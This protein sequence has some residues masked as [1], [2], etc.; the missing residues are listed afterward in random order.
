[1]LHKYSS[2]SKSFIKFC[3][4]GGFSLSIRFLSLF[5]LQDLAKLPFYLSYAITVVVVFTSGFF[6]NFYFVFSNKD[7]KRKKFIKFILASSILNLIDYLIS[8]ALVKAIIV[9]PYFI[10]G[11][12]TILM[13]GLKFLVFKKIIFKQ[14]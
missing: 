7:Q 6:I 11:F 3:T 10:V 14:D 1:M 13:F 12:V 9:S 8:N 4:G 5:I 2:L